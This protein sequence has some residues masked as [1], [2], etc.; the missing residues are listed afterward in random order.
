MDRRVRKERF[1][2]KCIRSPFSYIVL[3]ALCLIFSIS[4]LSTYK[5]SKIAQEKT[6][7]VEEH[8]R[9]LNQ[10]EDSLRAS[11]HDMNTP[12]GIEKSLREKFGIIKQGETAVIIL[13]PLPQ[14][15]E[16]E[17]REKQGIFGFFKNLF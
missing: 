7:Y 13:D 10:Q 1:L 11:L 8:L 14:E 9:D 12:F 16:E 2:S 6:R 4:A 15:E 17:Q 3:L 5:K